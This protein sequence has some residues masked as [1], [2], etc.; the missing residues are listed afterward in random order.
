MK[1]DDPEAD[2]RL[3]AVYDAECRWGPDD[4]FFL[5]LVNRG[6]TRRVID[7]GCGTGRLT[8]AIAAAG[9][10]VVGVDPN[11]TSLEAARLKPGGDRVT[12]VN[13]TSACMA[14]NSFDVAVMTS[15]VAQV[16]EE[17]GFTV[18]DV[19]GGWHGE[20]VGE[21]AGELVVVAQL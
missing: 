18:V 12:W 20:L 16:L 6:P 3:P 2:P 14:P 7:L 13:G 10:T 9:H 19:F 4:D 1:S 5:D 8:T 17:A 11:R 15:H 21:G